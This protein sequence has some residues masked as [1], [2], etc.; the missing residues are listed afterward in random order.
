MAAHSRTYRLGGNAVTVT[1]RIL[2]AQRTT[3]VRVRVVRIADQ[4]VR[5]NRH[6][7]YADPTRGAAAFDQ[8]CRDLQQRVEQRT[9]AALRHTR[10]T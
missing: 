4:A 10:H 2:P 9:R 1:R 7:D 8:Q 5:M 6:I 3:R